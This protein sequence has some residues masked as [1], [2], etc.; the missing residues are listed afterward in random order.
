MITRVSG[1][2]FRSYEDVELVFGSQ[3]VSIVY[4]DS[5][6][7]YADSNGTGKT[8]LMYLVLW[9]LYGKWPDMGSAESCLRQ[10]HGK[11]C[12]GV[13]TLNKPDGEWRVERHRKHHEHKNNVFVYAPGS[14]S[15]I[16]GDMKVVQERIEALVGMNY[17]T[18]VK[19]MVF[20]GAESETFA[21]MT[22]KQQKDLLDTIVPMDFQALY[23]RANE[24]LKFAGDTCNECNGVVRS[25]EQWI[26]RNATEQNHLKADIEQ[27]S[28]Q[29][30]PESY[31]HQLDDA[32]K[33][34]TEF[35]GVL[36][37][38][39]MK[40]AEL[41]V[42]LEAREKERD[43]Y[44]PTMEWFEKAEDTWV[45]Y[46][47]ATKWLLEEE[48]RHTRYMTTA[49]LEI[50][51][52][53][54]RIANDQQGK[55]CH[56]CGQTL[57]EQALAKAISSTQEDIQRVQ[58]EKAK[59]EKHYAEQTATYSAKQQATNLDDQSAAKLKQDIIEAKKYW[60]DLLSKIEVLTR[61]YRE[62]EDH[63][64][65]TR[66]SKAA[67]ESAAKELEEKVASSE[68]PT[69]EQEERLAFLVEEH[70]RL[71]GDLEQAKKNQKEWAD[72]AARW[73]DVRDMF[74]GGKNSLQHFL[75]ESMLPE[76][77]ATAQMFLSLFSQNELSVAFKSHKKKGSK[78]VEGF[79]VEALKGPNTKGYGDMSG[80][81]RRRLDLCIFLTI[82]LLACKHV[83]SPG[84]I[85]L[86]EIADFMDDTGQQQVVNVLE[87]L[88]QQY[89]VSCLLLTNKRE[90]VASVAHGY[91]CSMIDGTSRLV[92]IQ[93]T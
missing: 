2:N 79:F 70:E 22:D 65:S 14:V 20:T 67:W 88:C 75:F 44:R 12:S 8:T 23:D 61:Q 10:P 56:T 77:T 63:L 54:G 52:L 57:G 16:S 51:L 62:A 15:P 73:V 18:F 34:I 43:D 36:L 32:R 6:S 1:R 47:S 64:R 74:S 83:F 30:S 60:K 29:Y 39:E 25:I 42:E 4:G 46:E 89:N 11:D 82:H 50:Q 80:G 59:A 40:L 66:E 71:A 45:E 35:E 86:D 17:D 91:R 72:A 28:A 84:V 81:E 21:R 48:K 7:D 49:D 31:Q 68:N 69:K 37:G 33:R 92:S 93:E 90:L 24:K 87:F 78:T 26:E 5:E 13:L 76:M 19:T 85:F 9:T 55:V 58:Q 41:R 53:E 27:I 38:H 3:R